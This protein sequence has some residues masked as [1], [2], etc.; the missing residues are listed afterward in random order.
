M[1]HRLPYAPSHRD[2]MLALAQ[3]HLE[4]HVHAIDL[5]W[6][7]SSWALDD[8]ESI[9][10]WA[11]PLG[12]L[13]AWAVVQAPFWAID[14]AFHPTADSALRS[15]VWAWAGQRAH[16]LVGTAHGRP[17]WYVSVF[18]QQTALREELESAGFIDQSDVPEDPWSEILLTRS[19]QTPLPAGS[20]PPPA[21]SWR[22]WRARGRGSPA[23]ARPRR[24]SGRSRST[25]CAAAGARATAS[26]STTRC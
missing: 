18:A 1:L 16:E 26:G 12:K 22:C 14:Y 17:A 13:H 7:L 9:G 11:D 6:R 4:T 23:P 21:T 24:A 10:L 5:P 19:A 15:E 25:R 2:A 20:P 8:R 3:T